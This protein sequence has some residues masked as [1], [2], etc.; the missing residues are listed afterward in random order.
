MRP[1]LGVNN[2]KKPSEGHERNQGQQGNKK[3][4]RFHAPVA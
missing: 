1:F 2:L 4:S 3:N